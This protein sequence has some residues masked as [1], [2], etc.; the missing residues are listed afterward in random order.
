MKRKPSKELFFETLNSFPE[1]S[2]EESKE[3][4]SILNSMNEEDKEI[5]KTETIK[6]ED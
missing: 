6:I 5:V 1:C 3:I 4:L 2:K